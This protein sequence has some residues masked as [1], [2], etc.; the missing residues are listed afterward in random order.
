MQLARQVLPPALDVLLALHVS[1]AAV[2][3]LLV[4][5]DHIPLHLALVVV[6]QPSFLLSESDFL[7]L[8]CSA[9]CTTCFGSS[10]A[11]TGCSSSPPYLY[12]GTCYATCPGGSYAS[13]SSACTSMTSLLLLE[14]NV[15]FLACSA[16]CATCSGGPTTC[17]GCSGTT[18]YLYSGT[19]Y[20]TCPG[21]S[22]TS[23]S[24]VCTGMTCCPELMLTYL[25]LFSPL[26]NMFW[27]FDSLYRML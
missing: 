27:E 10:T 1:T 21:G 15:L 3:M 16:P 20:A 23:S 18:P 9:P 19:C 24:S 22:Y 25:S 4:L 7:F 12:S 17:T 14:P 8:A 6:Q 13:S 5:A 26:R 2:V 11:C